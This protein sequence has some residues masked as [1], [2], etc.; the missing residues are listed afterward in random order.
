MSEELMNALKAELE[1]AEK[2]VRLKY[3]ALDILPGSL[4]QELNHHVYGNKRRVK[5][6]CA[7]G[8]EVERATSDLFTFKGCPECLKSVRKANKASKKLSLAEAIA[9]LKKAEAA[10]VEARAETE[11]S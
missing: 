3:P 4:T 11:N 7:C 10:L 6:R 1:M 5:L 2:L 9:A 8:V